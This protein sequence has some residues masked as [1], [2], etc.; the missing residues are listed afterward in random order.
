MEKITGMLIY[1]FFVCKKKLWYFSHKITMESKNEDVLLGKLLDTNSYKK[2]EKH[3]NI[4][5]IINI[6]FIK[7]SKELHEIKK[8]IS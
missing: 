7:N 5:N 6:D 2:N 4:D 1:Y 3:I 8:N